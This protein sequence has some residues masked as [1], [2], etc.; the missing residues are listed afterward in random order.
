GPTLARITS[1]L[2]EETGAQL[3]YIYV[4]GDSVPHLHLHLAPHIAGDALNDQMI[5]GELVTKK[6]PS[7]LEL[8]ESK[9][10]PPLPEAEQRALAERLRRRLA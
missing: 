7:G 6:L 2:R 10:F 9:D 8:I 4:F 3:V 1:A 5:R